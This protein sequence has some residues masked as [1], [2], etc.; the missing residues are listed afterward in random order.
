M[1]TT[2]RWWVFALV[3]L[4]LFMGA[5]DNLVVTDPRTG[6]APSLLYT[7]DFLFKV[8]GRTYE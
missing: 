5:L 8:K 3:C 2:R 4:A 1:T 6:Q 7:S